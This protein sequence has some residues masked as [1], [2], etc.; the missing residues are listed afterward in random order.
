MTTWFWTHPDEDAAL[1]PARERGDLAMT[2][3]C[4]LLWI[5]CV[6]FA[7]FLFGEW[8]PC[9][10]VATPCALLATLLYWKCRGCLGTRIC[11]AII[12][13]VF[14]GVLID[15]AHGVIETHFSIFALLAFLL[16]YRD[17][18][19]VC[20]G[21]AV[22]I[23]HHFVICDLQMRGYPVFVFPAGQPCT[24]V[25]VHT[26]Y[27]IVETV[28]LIYLGAAIRKEALEASAIAGFSR[29]LIETGIIDLRSE[30]QSSVRSE[31]LD[32]LLQA[33]IAPS[34]RPAPSPAVWAPS[35]PRSPTRPAR[36]CAPAT[37][38]KPA[39]RPPSAWCAA[40]P[41]SPSTSPATA[42]KSQPSR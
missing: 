22:V 2:L 7:A 36:S 29:R 20:A 32:G 4:W 34:A 31:A 42:T 11:I 9:L 24:M 19:P 15:E 14:S 25:W 10:A 16:Y 13:V 5:A 6:C 26:A 23:A 40:W 17:W 30:Q 27:V 41:T 37:S 12:F 3:V 8:T 33:S 35:P 38:S 21:S 39:A 1:R 18:R 28:V